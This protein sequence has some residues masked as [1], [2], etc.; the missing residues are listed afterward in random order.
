MGV[1]RGEQEGAAASPFFCAEYPRIPPSGS[2][3]GLEPTKNHTK[4]RILEVGEPGGPSKGNPTTVCRRE[5]RV[6]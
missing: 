4:S 5:V 2:Y 3:V 6:N 1:P